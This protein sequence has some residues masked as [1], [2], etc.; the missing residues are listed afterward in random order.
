L[1]F[2]YPFRTAYSFLS[3]FKFTDFIEPLQ[4]IEF[5]NKSS[6]F[7]ALVDSGSQL[8]LIN[9]SLLPFLDYKPCLSPITNL[10]GVSNKKTG[11]SKWIQL[12]VTLPNNSVV[13][14]KFAVVD[15][16]PCVALFGLPL[17][18]SIRAVHD[19]YN[20][21]LQT[22]NGP[23][24]L[25]TPS[26]I[27]T[28]KSCSASIT[29]PDA[30]IDINFS[31]S[32]LPQQQREELRQLLLEFSDLWRGGCRGMAT[33]LEHR[34]RLSTT[35]PVV[36]RPRPITQE[37]MKVIAK[38]VNTM[39]EE[40]VIRPSSSPYASEVILAMKKTGDWR[41]CIDFRA[42]NK[43]TI[44]D[45]YPLPRISDLIHAIKGSKYFVALD[46]R[47]GYW[48]VP[49]EQQS[50]KY[51]AFRCFMG[52]FE[53]LR[54]PFGLTNAPATFQR[55]MDFLFGDLR[56]SGILTYIDDILI[57]SSTFKR[58]M[59]L[60]RVVLLRL[61]ANGIT[62]NLPKSIFFPRTLKYLGQFVIDGSI[63]PDQQKVEALRH[64]KPPTNVSEV[65]SLLGFL[66]FYHAFIPNFAEI[67]LPVFDLLRDRKNTKRS[68]KSTAVLWTEEHQKA[69]NKAVALLSKATLEIPSETDEFLIE[70]D[71]SGKAIGAVLHVK[72]KDQWKPVEFY[73]KTLS[74]T[75]QNWPAREREAFAIVAALQKFDHYVRGRSFVV[76][77]DH[78]SLKW[79]LDC[80]TGKIA[81]WAGLLAEYD[82]SIYHKKGKELVHID[83]LS[84]FI[85][86]E[87]DGT[88]LDR[89]CYFTSTSPIPPLEEILAAQKNSPI[90]NS[91]GFIVKNDI[92]YYHGLIYVPLSF[93]HKVIAA[94]HSI[95]PFHHPGIK[96]TKSTL[97]R[98][99]NWP[100][101]HRDISEYLQSCLYCR[102]CRSGKERLQGLLRSHPIP[103]AFDTVCMDFWQCH[104]G[105]KDYTVLTIIDQHTKWA[106]C[107]VLSSKSSEAVASAFLQ[108][109]IYRFGVPSRLLSD[110][111]PSFVSSF[112]TTLTAKLG[113][114]RLIS[115]VYHPEGNATIESFHRVLSTG[116]RHIDHNKIPFEEALNLVLFG[117]RSTPH[118]T[119]THSPS[120]L[121]H[122]IDPRLASDNDWRCETTPI[123]E[124]R[125]KF[126]SLLRLDVQLQA[127]NLMNR[128]NARKNE[129]RHPVVF[130]EG[131]LV[132][133]RLIPLDQLRYK[134]AFF[135]AVPRWTLPYRVVRIL[136]SKKTAIVQSL[137]TQS[138]REVHIQDVQFIQP[139]KDE[140]QRQ[141]WFDLVEREIKTIHDPSTCRNIIESFFE[142]IDFPQSSTPP[143]RIKRRRVTGL[144]GP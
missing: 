10:R 79:M 86:N 9:H 126:L 105:N 49:V 88:L 17:L 127:Q 65:R 4:F 91:P 42:L 122:G 120:F 115:T 2:L 132:L 134:T 23:I 102:R 82:M 53:F 130:E 11:I 142:A 84:R 69:V 143:A 44:K 144:G 100:N 97:M 96:K 68:N 113:I 95:A 33:N 106:E 66:G 35:R 21:I 112:I 36:A 59:E 32:T 1:S 99:F 93:R 110:K 22:T 123:N 71:A 119:T 61:R 56:F 108:S 72:T 73:S 16:L 111:D 129:S 29:N 19:I 67:M 90:P 137:V 58:T 125:F 30:S 64:I 62:L 60:L 45:Q 8:N 7:L 34:I 14:S 39:L 85:D 37:Q 48:Q 51:T 75:Q 117:Y 135:K 31:D 38:E 27:T 50:I 41:F 87:P 103:N 20:H 89:M 77:T 94:C 136:P 12:S 70:T 104:Y 76:H 6:S 131:Q 13:S 57:H 74:Q 15:D 138:I 81:R 40:K 52:L 46:L 124:E 98:T 109:W 47:S 114:N 128:Q 78:E 101:L 43:V 80:P 107:I 3:N 118:S 83:F 25:L 92:I 116:L 121:T 139:P 24:L 54:M 55:M 140:A 26:S 63:V 28:P 133:C 5:T 141:E 18:R